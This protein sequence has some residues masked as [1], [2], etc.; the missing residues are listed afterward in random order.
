MNEHL[1]MTASATADLVA[2]QVADH[3]IVFGDLIKA[4]AMR[5]HHE[6][7]RIAGN[8]DR[9]VA[10]GQ[11]AHPLGFKNATRIDEFSFCFALNRGR[12]GEGRISC[13]HT[14]GGVYQGGLG[15][16]HNARGVLIAG[17][18]ID[19]QPISL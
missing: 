19:H 6:V 4:M 12:A 5:L 1:A 18:E 17:L 16:I 13:Q 2:R 3:D 7:R 10:T 11:V 8:P 9:D 15:S 14:H